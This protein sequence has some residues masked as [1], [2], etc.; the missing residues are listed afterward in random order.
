[1]GPEANVSLLQQ[2]RRALTLAAVSAALHLVGFAA[3]VFPGSGIPRAVATC[4]LVS[5]ILAAAAAVVFLLR[6]LTQLGRSPAPA[7]ATGSASSSASMADAQDMPASPAAL[8]EVQATPPAAAAAPDAISIGSLICFLQGLQLRQMEEDGLPSHRP[9]IAEA[10][11]AIAAVLKGLGL[12]SEEGLLPAMKGGPQP[13]IPIACSITGLV[14]FLQGL[15]LQQAPA[16]GKRNGQWVADDTILALL[17]F[18]ASKAARRATWR[19][20]AYDVRVCYLDARS[21]DVEIPDW[22]STGVPDCNVALLVVHTSSETAGLH[23]SS[24]VIN[25]GLKLIHVFDSLS[26]WEGGWVQKGM[27]GGHDLLTR[28]SQGSMSICP[29]VYR[30]K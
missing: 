4:A 28:E 16:F 14:S 2:L 10:V 18:L 17:E 12:L 29:L 7:A 3:L 1:M 25:P 27:E 13:A 6:L 30:V 19:S 20:E 5:A 21:G 26:A 9:V 24:V 22:E 8:A 15:G 23:F 11:R